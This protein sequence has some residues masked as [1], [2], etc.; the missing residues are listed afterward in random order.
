MFAPQTLWKQIITFLYYFFEEDW[1]HFELLYNVCWIFIHK[2]F[3]FASDVLLLLLLWYLKCF[4]NGFCTALTQQYQL[5]SQF[6]GKTIVQPFKLFGWCF[7]VK[8]LDWH[9]KCLVNVFW[10]P[11]A[12]HFLM[13]WVFLVEAW[14][15]NW[16]CMSDVHA[17]T[18]RKHHSMFPQCF[19]PAIQSVMEMLHQEKFKHITDFLADVFHAR[20]FQTWLDHWSSLVLQ[21]NNTW[22]RPYLRDFGMKNINQK[23]HNVLK[24]FLVKHCHD[25]L[26]GWLKTL[27]KHRVMFSLGLWH[28]HHSYIFNFCGHASSKKNSKHQE[29]FCHWM[30]ENID[31]TFQMSIQCF[32]P[33]KP[34]K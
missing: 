7:G 20:I 10:H 4:H 34:I 28:E 22:G 26:N 30:L 5:L 15:Q 9:L 27:R 21:L 31:K 1:K 19:Q 2:H 25:T 8:T 24:L 14:P 3:G 6:Y 16:K 17:R 32:S 13:F 33:K 18:Q 23:S 11:M 29:M 12:K